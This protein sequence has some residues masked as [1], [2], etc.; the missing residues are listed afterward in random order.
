[1]SFMT[2]LVVTVEIEIKI[3][4]ILIEKSL[5]FINDHA[6]RTSIQARPIPGAG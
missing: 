5:C 6:Y 4:V 2:H 3:N 1:M